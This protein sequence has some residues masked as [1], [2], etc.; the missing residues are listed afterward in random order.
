MADN[1]AGTVAINLVLNNTAFNNQVKN[2]VKSTENAF[3]SAFKTVGTVIATAFAV[4][5]VIE[6][7]RTVVK[8]ALEKGLVVISAGSNV[9]RMVPPLVIEKEH[10]DEMIEKLDAVLA[11]L[12][13]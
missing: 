11:E 3:T 2:S 10:V 7:G 9:I 5:K 6:F 13:A 8:A 12:E 4:D 1:S